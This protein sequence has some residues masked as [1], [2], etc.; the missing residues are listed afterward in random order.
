M[1]A[2]PFSINANTAWN[3]NSYITT[4]VST[5]IRNVRVGD[6][7]SGYAYY[8]DSGQN[9]NPNFYAVNLATGAET[10][11]GNAGQLTGGGSFGIWTVLE[12]GGFLY[13]QTT[14]N[15][16]QVYNMNSATSLGS[17]QTAYSK[18]TIDRVTGSSGQYFGLDVTPDG[19]KMLL[20]GLFGLIF[21]FGQPEL[22][23]SQAGSDLILSWPASVNSVTLQH[24]PSLSP[25]NFTD[26]DPQPGVNN[27]G[28]R[29]TAIVPIT[30][31]AEFYRLRREENPPE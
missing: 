23:V 19:S 18:A 11:L 4:S 29:N 27:D 16:I 7:Y 2:E 20:S 12:R 15:G 3:A 5:R 1:V 6:V 28:V 26:L 13:V 24:S 8:G 9:N 10:L 22:S 14:D 31:A 30:G 21:E 17:L 25:A